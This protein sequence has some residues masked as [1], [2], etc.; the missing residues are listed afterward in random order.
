MLN[1]QESADVK[2][3]ESEDPARTEKSWA[4]AN[5]SV[6]YHEHADWASAAAHVLSVYV[7]FFLCERITHASAHSG[8]ESHSRSKASISFG[9]LESGDLPCHFT[10]QSCLRYP[11]TVDHWLSQGTN[12][13]CAPIAVNLSCA[14]E[15]KV[16]YKP[17]EWIY[18][19]FE[20]GLSI[21]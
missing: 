7:R 12:V 14:M 4:C 6:H 10:K 9:C 11:R 21:L 2:T 16:T 13:C 17:S 5:C 20:C 18:L 3:K 8:M 1:Q 15:C 19:R